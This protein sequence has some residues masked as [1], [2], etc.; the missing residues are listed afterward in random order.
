MVQQ[1]IGKPAARPRK[2]GA[3]KALVPPWAAAILAAFLGGMFT[4]AALMAAFAFVSERFSLTVAAVRPLAL[5]AAWCA[6][7]VSGY[8]LAGR[9]GQ[10]RLLCGLL[11]GLFYSACLLL[12]SFLAAGS[13]DLQGANLALPISL[14]LGGLVGGL[15]SAMRATPGAARH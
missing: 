6:S 8:I 15:V 5:A 13:I 11:C 14:L 4:L 3:H 7:A 1:K 2:R 10:Q 12:A 9:L